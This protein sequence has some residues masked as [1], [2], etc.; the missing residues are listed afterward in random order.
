[1]SIRQLLFCASVL[2]ALPALGQVPVSLG[3][4]Q[5][6]AA[7][8]TDVSLARRALAS[9]RADVLVADHA[10]APVL[11]TKASQ[12]DLQNGIGAGNAFTRKRIDKSLG[13]DW[14][15]ERGNK[16]ELRTAAA[17][18]LAQA[19]EAD[20]QE[21]RV[22]QQIAASSAFWDLAAAQERALNVEAAGRHAADLAATAARRVRAGDLAAQEALRTDIEAQRAAGELV[23]SRLEQR[24]AELALA[25]LMGLPGAPAL[26]AQAAW[27]QLQMQAAPPLAPGARADVRAAQSRVEA[28]QAALDGALATRKADF[29]VGSSI[30]H[31]PGTSSRML[32]VRLQVPL[33]GV[34]GSYHQQGEI[35]RAQAQL[36]QARDTLDKATRA[37]EADAQRLR[38]EMD[39]AS[40]RA[41]GYRSLIVPR[42]R[43]V[44][45]MAELAYSKGA[46]ALTELID[47]RR[48]L[49]SVQLEDIAARAD[50]ARALS[51]WQLRA[52]PPSL[53]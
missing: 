17:Q 10:P 19:A 49:R 46:T 7:D 12:V 21:T 29:T 30:D 16:R 3:Q 4:A 1:M 38:Q 40:S 45:D 48:T 31:F 22:Q 28:A 50:Y 41:A 47:A 42:A 24:R 6:A 26:Q 53:P 35:A 8:N 20:L 33:Q 44:A 5:Q 11:T 27:P 23:S 39:S 14:T 52:Q 51:T 25:Q 36:D 18:R 37:A 32:E 13:V 15:W 9:A 34:L 2:A 43:Q